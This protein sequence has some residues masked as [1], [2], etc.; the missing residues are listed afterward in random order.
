MSTEDLA[1]LTCPHHR[2]VEAVPS[3]AMTVV[4]VSMLGIAVPAIH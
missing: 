1:S 2:S 4:E 3:L